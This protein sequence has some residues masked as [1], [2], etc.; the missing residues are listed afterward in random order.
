[1]ALPMGGQPMNPML[2][3]ALMQAHMQSQGGQ[4]MPMGGMPGGIGGPQMPGPQQKIGAPAQVPMIAPPAMP[5]AAQPGM[6][7]NM[8]Q[9]PQKMMGL[10]AMLKKGWG[11]MGGFGGGGGAGAGMMGP[12]ATI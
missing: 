4:G 11:G 3:Q 2:M 6:M 8:M 10:L 9:D 7:Q 5:G 1:M 12:T